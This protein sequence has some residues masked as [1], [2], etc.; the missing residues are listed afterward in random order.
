MKTLAVLFVF[1]LC[2]PAAAKSNTIL[3][4]L[5]TIEQEILSAYIAREI[6]RTAGFGKNSKNV[7]QDVIDHKDRCCGYYEI[8]DNGVSIAVWHAPGKPTIPAS[9]SRQKFKCDGQYYT[10]GH[11]VTRQQSLAVD[12]VAHTCSTD[13]EHKIRHVVTVDFDGEAY[14]GILFVQQSGKMVLTD[15]QLRVLN[16]LVGYRLFMSIIIERYNRKLR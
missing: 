12:R 16:R 9:S 7:K 2:I 6:V 8:Y 1:L 15:K 11:T 13:S 4:T 10:T 3:D 5:D 14:Q